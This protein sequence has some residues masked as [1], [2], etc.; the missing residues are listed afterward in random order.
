[1]PSLNQNSA[2]TVLVTFPLYTWLSTHML[3]TDV[4]DMSLDE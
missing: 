4:R 2:I 3:D 1:M